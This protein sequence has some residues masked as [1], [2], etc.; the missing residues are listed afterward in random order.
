MQRN[1]WWPTA[2]GPALDAG[3]F[4]TGLEYAARVEATVVGKPAREIYVTACELLG[5]E[6]ARTAMVGDDPESDLAPAR[7]AGMTICLVRTGKGSS[8]DVAPG[9]VDLDLPG[10][11]ALPAEL[12]RIEGWQS[13]KS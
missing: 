3:L 5:S 4:V 11:A 8:F 1:R 7:A 6:P 10:L 9:D 13:A 2:E 12:R